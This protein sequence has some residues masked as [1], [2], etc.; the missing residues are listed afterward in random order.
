MFFFY[1]R[2]NAASGVERGPSGVLAGRRLVKPSVFANV[3]VDV[4]DSLRENL[5][6]IYTYV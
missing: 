4:V 3:E 5:M 6:K 2:I 1:D